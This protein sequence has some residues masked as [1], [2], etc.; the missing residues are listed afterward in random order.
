MASTD[1]ARASYHLPA[2]RGLADVWWKEGR[3]SVK[4]TGAETGGA[5][6]QVVTDDPRGTAPPLHVHHHED[7]TFYVLDG[8]LSVIVDGQEQR[9][10]TGDYAVVPRGVPHAY[11]VRSERARMLV[12]FSPAGFEQVFVEIGVPA[13]GDEPPADAVFPTP[14]EAGRIFAAYGCELVGPP[15]SL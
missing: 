14:D 4:L 11:L 5:L 9:L 13:I 15:P 8:E 12:T 2:D 6:A 3:I 10:S 7:E 1:N